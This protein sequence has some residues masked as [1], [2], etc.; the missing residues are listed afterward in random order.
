M[1]MISKVIELIYTYKTPLN[2]LSLP[3]GRNLR[4]I[5]HLMHSIERSV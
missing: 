5:L 4:E 2:R 3:W 1:E